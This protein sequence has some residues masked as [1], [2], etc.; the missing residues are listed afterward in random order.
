MTAVI[1]VDNKPC[2]PWK[3]YQQV[4]DD[5]GTTWVAKMGEV[6]AHHWARKDGKYLI[7]EKESITKWHLDWQNTLENECGMQLEVIRQDNN[8]LRRADALCKDRKVVVE[9]QHSAISSEDLYLRSNFW[10]DLGYQVIWVFSYPK[11]DNQHQFSKANKTAVKPPEEERLYEVWEKYKKGTW[12]L[13]DYDNLRYSRYPSYMKAFEEVKDIVIFLEGP[14][15][16]YKVKDYLLLE[17]AKSFKHSVRFVDFKKETFLS[18][19][20]GTPT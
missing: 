13:N 11:I 10:S 8:T 14:E 1:Y 16:L 18:L 5:H 4:K 6:N 12:S 3:R 2:R 15:N 9:V 17:D 20:N 19:L 7:E